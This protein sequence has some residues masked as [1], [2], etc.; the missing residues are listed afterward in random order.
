MNDY[1]TNDP[2]MDPHYLHNNSNDVSKE[3]NEE[4]ESRE[5]IFKRNTFSGEKNSTYLDMYGV[6]NIGEKETARLPSVEQNN[7]EQEKESGQG[8]DSEREFRSPKHIRSS[9]RTKLDSLI[10]R[11]LDEH[12]SIKKVNQGFEKKLERIETL[13]TR[14]SEQQQG[15]PFSAQN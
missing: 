12:N 11:V 14:L 7:H 10:N 13:I 2:V 1:G 5:K 9:S 8:S 15:H 3:I 4:Y 6:S